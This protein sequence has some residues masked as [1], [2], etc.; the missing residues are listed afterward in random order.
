MADPRI[1]M[2]TSPE[3]DDLYPVTTG[4]AVK[5]SEDKTLDQAFEDKT[6]EIDQTLEQKALEIR[7][8][9]SDA[10]QGIDAS[11]EEQKQTVQGILSRLSSYEIIPVQE[12]ITN[13]SKLAYT[14]PATQVGKTAIY[15]IHLKWKASSSREYYGLNITLPSGKYNLVGEKDL[16]YWYGTT[17]GNKGS[18]ELPLNG[19]IGGETVNLIS[20]SNKITI[21]NNSSTWYVFTAL[22][23][24][25]RVS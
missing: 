4:E 23:I 2:M 24:L 9:F 13:A 19:E 1:I 16:N 25:H 12:T 15:P 17:Q 6:Q 22:W 14:L 20:S 7:E 8:A 18:Y 21:T 10:I 3:G 5:M 11:I